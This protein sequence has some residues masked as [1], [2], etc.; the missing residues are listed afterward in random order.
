[1]NGEA[2]A[3]LDLPERV[4][5]SLAAAVAQSGPQA[6]VVSTR[7]RDSMRPPQ[8]H[9]VA[10]ASAEE[11]EAVRGP[12]R[13]V[14]RLELYRTPYGP[15]VRLAFTVYPEADEPL[16]AA[17]VLDVSRVSGDAALSSLGRQ[18]ELPVHLYA[19]REGDLAYAF[20]KVIP[21]EKEQRE[22]ARK[23]LRM[24]RESYSETPEGRRSFRRALS[25]AGRHFEL[26]VP[27]PGRQV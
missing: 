6:R 12:S 17:T 14:R 21:N 3:G 5:R 18:K 2:Q 19:A 13:I 27:E 25:L 16:S 26:P 11:A 10:A 24:A 4:R 9:V 20:S 8:A 15:V 7:A 1:M 23:V 22:E